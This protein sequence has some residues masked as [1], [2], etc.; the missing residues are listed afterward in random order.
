MAAGLAAPELLHSDNKPIGYTTTIADGRRKRTYDK[1]AAQWQ[2]L[3]AS[4]ISDER[5]LSNVAARIEGIHTANLTRQTNA[6]HLQLLDLARAK[7]EALA[8]APIWKHF[9]RQS[10]DW[11]RPSSARLPPAHHTRGIS[12]NFTLTFR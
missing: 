12:R 9:N 4:E 5:R 2:H 3:Q 7:T 1:P 11:P 8:A 10:S 6:V